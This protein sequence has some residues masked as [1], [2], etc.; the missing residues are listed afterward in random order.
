MGMFIRSPE[1]VWNPKAL[2]TASVPRKVPHRI[3][4]LPKGGGAAMGARVIFENEPLRYFI[5]LSPFVAAMFM[6]GARGTG[7]CHRHSCARGGGTDFAPVFDACQ[8]LDPSL[9]IVLTGLDAPRPAAPRRAVTW[10]VPA[11]AP[12]PP[13]FGTVLVMAR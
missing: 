7:A 2:E 4:F 8:R 13:A 3:A 1:T 5:A 12:R 10:T 6:G 9:L 11:P